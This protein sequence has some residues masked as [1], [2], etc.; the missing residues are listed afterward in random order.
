MEAVLCVFWII[1]DAVKDLP[2]N[3][4]VQPTRGSHTTFT[5]FLFILSEGEVPLSFMEVNR[6][7]NSALLTIP[8]SIY[9]SLSYS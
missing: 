8:S 4:N 5:D 7:S 3:V 9:C 2:V 6:F 1:C